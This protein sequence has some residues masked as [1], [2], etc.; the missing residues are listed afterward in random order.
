[1]DYEL[2]L[3]NDLEY[4]DQ[5]AYCSLHEALSRLRRMLT[6][7]LQ[8]VDEERSVAKCQVLIQN[9]VT[10]VKLKSRTFIAGTTMSN[11][12]SPQAR[13][14]TLIVSTFDSIAIKL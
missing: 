2:L 5:Q 11:D 13:T 14:G 4:L 1:L 3:A 7:L 8:K 9:L 12:S 6:S 10:S